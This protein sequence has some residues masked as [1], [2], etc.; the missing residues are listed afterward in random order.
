MSM[1]RIIVG[2]VD[3]DADTHVGAVIDT[4]GAIL[5]IGS[6]PGRRVGI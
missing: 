6:F 1:V 5:G 2:G 3:T 4:N